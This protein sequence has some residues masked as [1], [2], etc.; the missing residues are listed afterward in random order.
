MVAYQK[1]SYRPIIC[2]LE[3]PVRPTDRETLKDEERVP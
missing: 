1:N 2:Y 3:P